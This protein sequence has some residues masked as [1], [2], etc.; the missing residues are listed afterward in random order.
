MRCSRIDAIAVI[1]ITQ[2]ANGQGASQVEWNDFRCR[3]EVEYLGGLARKTDASYGT[4]LNAFKRLTDIQRLRSVNAR[5]LGEFAISLRGEG[6]SEST[7]EGYLRQLKVAL[8][9]AHRQEML[10]AVPEFPVI[11][12]AHHRKVMKGRAVT[13]EEFERLIEAVPEV[14]GGAA[15]PEWISLWRGLWWGGLR[16]GEA[17]NLRWKALPHD[18]TPILVDLDGAFPVFLVPAAGEKA[19]TDRILPMAPE[20]AQLLQETPDRKRCG[21]VF[22]VTGVKGNPIQS[23][24][25]ASRIG[26]K[27]GKVAGIVV[28]TTLSGKVKYASAHDLRRAF[29]TRWSLR[30]MPAV[31]KELMR[32]A[33]ISTTMRF[34]VGQ[35]AQATAATVWAAMPNGRQES[36]TLGNG[37]VRELG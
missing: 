22:R 4:A 6:K 8:R 9:W 23:I 16:L 2:G 17:L 24:D 27:F 15:A 32:H 5:L 35:N 33:D 21:R 18:D 30:V 28:D 29:G 3:F 25:Y 12:R 19:H 1:V 11:R 37:T 36:N 34:Y 10:P 7:I 20:F 14:V 26:A 31:L 13:G